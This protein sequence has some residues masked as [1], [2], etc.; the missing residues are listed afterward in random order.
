MYFKMILMLIV[1]LK[2]LDL[3]VQEIA[4]KV[5]FDEGNPHRGHGELVQAFMG[6]VVRSLNQ[7]LVEDDV[8]NIEGSV[9]ENVKPK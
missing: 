1:S 8:E 5:T 9:Q 6:D 4:P 3:N 2:W 7:G